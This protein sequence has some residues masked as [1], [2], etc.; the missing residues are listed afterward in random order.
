MFLYIIPKYQSIFAYRLQMVNS[1]HVLAP[2]NML[3]K[4]PPKQLHI[5]TILEQF[6]WLWKMLRLYSHV[7]HLNRIKSDTTLSKV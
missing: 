4:S 6:Y 5:M 1:N 7:L 3:W 2:P